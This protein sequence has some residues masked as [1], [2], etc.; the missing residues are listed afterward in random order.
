MGD[1]SW[2]TWPVRTRHI[3]G[4]SG[5]G[6]RQNFR[7]QLLSNRSQ[8]RC[9]S[10]AK[11]T[12]KPG[13]KPVGVAGNHLLV[14]AITSI[15]RPVPLGGAPT[16]LRPCWLV[17][18]SPGA[19]AQ[20]GRKSLCC[21][22]AA[23]RTRAV[24]CS[25][26]SGPNRG[27]ASAP[28]PPPGQTQTH[29]LMMFHEQRAVQC[30]PCILTTP[31]YCTASDVQPACRLGVPAPNPWQSRKGTHAGQAQAAAHSTAQHDQ[32]ANSQGIHASTQQGRP[33]PPGAVPRAA[34]N[35][36]GVAR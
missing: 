15:V 29:C 28:L 32:T 1:A 23:C 4:L 11:V 17:P 8:K 25:P 36:G 31:A 10:A 16:L 22:A 20:G 9:E 7:C 6:G 34:Q 30:L 13:K 21:R 33:P 35:S 14:C 3:T 12:K 27:G 26:A 19:A 24:Q 5:P 18:G 2:G